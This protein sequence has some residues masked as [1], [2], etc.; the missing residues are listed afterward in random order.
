MKKRK[1]LSLFLSIALTATLLPASALAEDDYSGELFSDG[2]FSDGLYSEEGS[3]EEFFSDG[4]FLEGEP[5]AKS[6]VDAV[7]DLIDA[8]PDAGDITADNAEEVGAK[9]D[10]IDEA[11]SALTDDELDALDFTKYD[12]AI[13]ALN[14]LAGQ[15]GAAKPVPLGTISVAYRDCDSN[16]Q[17]WETR[18]CA[19]ATVVEPDTITWS[20]GWYVVSSDVSFNKR[21]IVN[22]NVRLILKDGCT[23]TAD[24]YGIQVDK[25]KSLTI[26]GQAGGTGRL[27]SVSCDY[28]AGIGG[29][30]NGACG[31]VII[32]GG[33]I[34]ASGS[35]NSAGI[36]SSGNDAGNYYGGNITINGGNVTA[37]GGGSAAGIGGGA[38]RDAGVITINGGTVVAKGSGGAAGIGGGAYEG[39]FK[40]KAGS[41]GLI[42]INGGSVNEGYSGTEYSIGGGQGGTSGIVFNR[43]S[44]AIISA[45]QTMPISFTIEEGRTLVIEEGVTFTIPS[46]VTGTINGTLDVQGG[47]VVRGNLTGSGATYVD[48]TLSGSGRISGNIYYSLTL[49]DCTSPD[50]VTYNAKIYAESGATI[51]LTGTNVSVGQ[52]V[53]GWTISDTGV[54]VENNAFTMPAKALTV[55]VS[56][57]VN[58][59][60]YTVTIPATE[61]LGGTATVSASGV[62]VVSGSCL[63]VTLSGTSGTGNNFKL[64]TAEGA[65]L[66]YTITRAEQESGGIEISGGSVSASGSN[67]SVT[68]GSTVLTVAGGTADS[69]GS[70]TLTFSAPTTAVRYSGDYKGTVTFT[71]SIEDGGDT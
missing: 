60:T 9:L 27:I 39:S 45:S 41:G 28:D 36:G 55:S 34:T 50:T 71:V 65:E 23:L 14:A 12:A 22:G 2:L 59:P 5:G 56:G 53:S 63:V 35:H 1:W 17:N 61:E 18:T 47:L 29:T 67:T 43:S 62:N 16:G 38:G 10:E 8:L 15:A 70:T 49:T 7:Q 13:A 21:I 46:N 51:T 11:K 32:N 54:T 4:L 30:K 52:A 64:T 68:V 26:Y 66:S 24:K 42:I 48:G 25:G 19:D 6:G 44:T 31:T 69:S 58:A 33:I 37:N 57:Y 3:V 20:T 40:Q